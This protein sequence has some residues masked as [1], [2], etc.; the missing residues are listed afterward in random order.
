MR[1]RAGVRQCRADI[2]DVRHLLAIEPLYCTLSPNQGCLPA[3]PPVSNLQSVSAMSIDHATVRRIARL[4]RLTVAESAIG[5][6]AG[7]LSG[8]LGLADQLAAADVAGIEPM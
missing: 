4:A 1:L 7:E 3:N 8:V 5:S 6:L 2:R